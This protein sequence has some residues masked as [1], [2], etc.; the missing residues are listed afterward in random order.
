MI[1]ADLAVM[2]GRKSEA[3]SIEFGWSEHV[4]APVRL[5]G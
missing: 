5:H 3:D 2:R 4:A 1:P